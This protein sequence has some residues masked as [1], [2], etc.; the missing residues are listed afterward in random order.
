MNEKNENTPTTKT[1]QTSISN[2]G[3]SNST[4]KESGRR[5]GGEVR[6]RERCYVIK[7]K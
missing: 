1:K 3:T 6:D 4:I 2:L 7:I 5:V